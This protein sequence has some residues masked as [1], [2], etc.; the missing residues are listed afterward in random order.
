VILAGKRIL[1]TGVL[2]RHSISYG[3][4]ERSLAQGA[5]VVLTSFGPVRGLTERTAK[6]LGVESQ[7]IE[8]DVNGGEDLSRLAQESGPLDGVVHTITQAPADAVG[9]DLSGASRANAVAPLETSAY[10]LKALTEAALPALRTRAESGSGSSIVG[11]EIN[12]SVTSSAYELMG[13]AT[14]GA[15]SIARNLARDLA[16]SGIRVNLVSAGRLRTPAS[17]GVDRFG[18]LARNWKRHAAIGGNS[19]DSEPAADAAVFLLSELS[20]TISGQVVHVDDGRSS[21]APVHR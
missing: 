7:V 19:R 4:A 18:A 21:V 1:V 12:A 13:V 10:S 11:L 15:A 8:L 5:E 20:R 14:A 16:A 3:L 2:S 17:S 9:G 6:S